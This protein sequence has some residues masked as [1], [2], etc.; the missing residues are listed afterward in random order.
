ML[1]ERNYD[2]CS[3]KVQRKGEFRGNEF[4]SGQTQIE[5]PIE[6]KGRKVHQVR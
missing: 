6:H 1:L 3:Y 5:F 2:L 4:S